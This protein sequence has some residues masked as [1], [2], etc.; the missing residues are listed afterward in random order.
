MDVKTDRN[1]W[2]KTKYYLLET[3]LKKNLRNSQE[4]EE[5]KYYEPCI[6]TSEKEKQAFRFLIIDHDGI[7]LTENPPK[8]MVRVLKFKDIVSVN[9]EAEKTDFLSGSMQENSQHIVIKYITN[10][11]LDKKVLTY[12]KKAIKGKN[13]YNNNLNNSKPELQDLFSKSVHSSNSLLTTDILKFSFMTDAIDTSL[14]EYLDKVSTSEISKEEDKINKHLQKNVILIPIGENPT[15]DHS[16]LSLHAKYSTNIN[17][18]IN[19][20]ALVIMKDE[21]T[22]IPLSEKL[23]KRRKKD[24]GKEHKNGTQHEN[25]KSSNNTTILFE[26]S[27]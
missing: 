2:Y 26:N 18:N 14:T 5:V 7:I 21:K 20:S 11:K 3:F 12:F 17:D 10:L 13:Q 6:V 8:T 16:T 15:N 1:E 27:K 24:K 9:L 25:N 19:K 4:Y 23:S 22:K